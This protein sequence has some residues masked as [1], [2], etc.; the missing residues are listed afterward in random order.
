[1]NTET[2]IARKMHI[3]HKAV[4]DAVSKIMA[5]EEHLRKASIGVKIL[6]AVELSVRDKLV[7][8][9]YGKVKGA[10]GNGWAIT[11][12][13]K[14]VENVDL[15]ETGLLEIKPAMLRERIPLLSTPS[16]VKYEASKHMRELL[17]VVLLKIDSAYAE[18]IKES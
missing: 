11:A 3:V 1:M 5:A 6:C 12:L 8:L 13:I 15:E 10:P 16:L 9:G 4:G 7:V 14:R 17:D 2:E 18:I